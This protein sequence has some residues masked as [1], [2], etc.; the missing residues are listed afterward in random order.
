MVTVNSLLPYP[1]VPS[2]TP[3][4]VRF[5]HNTCAT[6]K[7]QTDTSHPNLD[8]TVGQKLG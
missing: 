2:L 8:L 7:R 5:S 4:G 6:D 3:D 1:T